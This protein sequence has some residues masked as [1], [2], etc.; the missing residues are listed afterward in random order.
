MYNYVRDMYFTTLLFPRESHPRQIIDTTAA[1][2]HLASPSHNPSNHASETWPSFIDATGEV[3]CK[4]IASFA[5]R[6]LGSRAAIEHEAW[7]S[8]VGWILV[9]G[10]DLVVWNRRVARRLR[11]LQPLVPGRPAT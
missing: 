1:A 8:L 6:Y 11:L 5:T 4:P 7:H 9:A 2:R 10:G 3:M